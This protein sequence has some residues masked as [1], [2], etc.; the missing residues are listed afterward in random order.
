MVT[1]FFKSSSVLPHLFNLSNLSELE[2][3]L[4][5]AIYPPGSSF[6][7]FLSVL[8][9]LYFKFVVYDSV[10]SIIRHE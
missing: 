3:D 4:K 7:L 10:Y 8:S 9:N 1:I 2:A 5:T 6:V